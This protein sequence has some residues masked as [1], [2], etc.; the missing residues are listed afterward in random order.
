M[1]ENEIEKVEEAIKKVKEEEKKE[2]AEETLEEI[3]PTPAIEQEEFPKESDTIK[4][5][6][7]ENIDA[8][9]KSS[10]VVEG[11]KY[12]KNKSKKSKKNIIIITLVILIVVT[13]GLLLWFLYSKNKQP[14][15]KE[16]TTVELSQKK[17]KQILQTY[18]SN[19]EASIAV[20]YMK[21]QTIL[22]YEEAVKLT[23]NNDKVSCNIHEIYSD[24]KIYLDECT[25][26]GK[27]TKYTYGTKQEIKEELETGSNVI[28]VYVNKNTG[29]KTTDKPTDMTNYE[30][31]K[32]TTDTNYLEASIFETSDYL[33]YFDQDYNGY[34]K[35]YKTDKKVLPAL[36]YTSVIPIKKDGY[37]SGTYACFMIN[38][39]WGVYNLTTG[40]QTVPCIY[41]QLQTN[42]R[43]G[44]SGPDT[45]I[46][47]LGDSFIVLSLN[48]NMGLINYTNNTTIIPVIYKHIRKINNYLVASQDYNSTIQVFDY[49]GKEYLQDIPKK[50]GMTSSGYVFVVEN[51]HSKLYALDKTMLYDFGEFPGTPKVNF[52]YQDLIQYVKD[53]QG[54][55]CIEYA[56]DFDTKKGMVTDNTMCG[57]IAKPILYLYPKKKTK[58]TVKFAH[59]ELLKTTYPKYKN[60]WVVTAHKNG[61]LYDKDGKYYYGLYWDEQKVH[62][63]DFSTGFYVEAKNAISFLEKTLA[64][65]GLNKKEKNEFIMYWLPYLERNEKSLVYFELTK[66]RESYDKINI[67]PKPDSLLRLV[68]HIKKVDEK[69]SIEKQKLPKFKRTGFVAVEWGG[70]TY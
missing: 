51:N 12:P 19:M 14:V 46:D 30:V 28:A 27:K 57:G 67:S 26:Q 70:T 9:K 18:G 56:Y 54:S 36:N 37:Y 48:N 65:I 6:S 2:V 66:E 1:K 11:Q 4:N 32:V 34:I 13:I 61:D 35:N 17:Q 29:K 41:D 40:E 3:I 8:Q 39:K 55:S 60:Q 49:Y 24:G 23:H 38:G 20:E 25:I 43:L 21:S 52:Y 22:P 59:P 50:Y 42:L 15:E 69:V 63:V 64:D 47:T 44:I 53:E 16:K 10:E 62:T 5:M 68:I 7:V 45:K 58:V 33:V 31:Y